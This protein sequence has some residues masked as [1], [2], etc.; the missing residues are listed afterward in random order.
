MTLDRLGKGTLIKP[1]NE[2]KHLFTF[3]QSASPDWDHIG[4]YCGVKLWSAAVH[5][6][7][8]NSVQRRFIGLHWPIVF[9]Y[10]V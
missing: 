7:N 8:L 6:E 4:Y 5:G 2:I 3:F 10:L 1:D 9:E